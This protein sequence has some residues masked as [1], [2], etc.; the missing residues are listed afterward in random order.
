M[1]PVLWNR[2]PN[3]IIDSGNVDQFKKKLKMFLFV[4]SDF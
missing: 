3:F 1:G 2:L 4:N